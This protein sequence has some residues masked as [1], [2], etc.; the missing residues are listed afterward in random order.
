MLQTRD[1]DTAS[2]VTLTCGPTVGDP[3][4]EIRQFITTLE[5]EHLEILFNTDK[6]CS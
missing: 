5:E 1:V 6:V 2:T 4:P 3:V